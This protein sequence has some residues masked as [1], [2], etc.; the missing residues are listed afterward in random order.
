MAD[1]GERTAG[2]AVSLVLPL[3]VG[4]CADFADASLL[5]A[6]SRP[7]WTTVSMCSVAGEE[8]APRLTNSEDRDSAV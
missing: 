6:D 7:L 3:P 8:L 2:L 5:R 1:L 4:L